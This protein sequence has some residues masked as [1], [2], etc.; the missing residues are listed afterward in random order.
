MPALSFTS[1][2]MWGSLSVFMDARRYRFYQHIYHHRKT[3]QFDSR[4]I[5]LFWE[6][7]GIAFMFQGLTDIVPSSTCKS[8]MLTSIAWTM[9][10]YDDD[11]SLWEALKTGCFLK[12]SDFGKLSQFGWTKWWMRDGHSIDSIVGEWEVAVNWGLEKNQNFVNPPVSAGD[13]IGLLRRLVDAID[14]HKSSS[15]GYLNGVNKSIHDLDSVC[16]GL[17]RMGLIV[18]GRIGRPTLAPDWTP[19]IGARLDARHWRPIGRPTLAPDWTPD[20]GARLDARHW[21]PDIG[22]PTLDA[23]LDARQRP[24]LVPDWTPDIGA[25]LDARY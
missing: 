11:K 7:L 24:T 12:E 1:Q 8:G 22:R 13:V 2:Y 25:R 18:R 9:D 17:R 14:E 15:E 10:M 23:R 4:Y 21:T 20:I 16:K 5:D 3:I 6:E 19:D